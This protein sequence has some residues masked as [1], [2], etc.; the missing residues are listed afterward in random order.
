M[1][2]ILCA[3]IHIDNG[4]EYPHGQ[5]SVIKG[6]VIG[7]FSHDEIRKAILCMIMRE[8]AIQHDGFLTTHN[9]FVS[10][11][12]AANIAYNAGQIKKQ[13]AELISD[14]IREI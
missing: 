6:F 1:E 5:R 10:R 2:K 9:R 8:R 13:I 7:G 11:K 4:I 14:D 3:A 12:T